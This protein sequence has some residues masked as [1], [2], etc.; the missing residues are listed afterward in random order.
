MYCTFVQAMFRYASIAIRAETVDAGEMLTSATTWLASLFLQ[1]FDT[2]GWIVTVVPLNV[3]P[4]R[5]RCWRG[6]CHPCSAAMA[7][8]FAGTVEK[9]VKTVAKTGKKTAKSKTA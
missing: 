2:A 3:K 8:I 1:C 5:S 9:P 7:T 4:L 6:C